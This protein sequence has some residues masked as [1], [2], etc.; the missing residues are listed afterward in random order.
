MSFDLGL[1]AKH[2]TV[3]PFPMTAFFIAM[4][5]KAYQGLSAEQKAL[6]DKSTGLAMSK[7][8]G[9]LYTKASR[10][11]LEQQGQGGAQIRGLQ[12]R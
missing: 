12:K 6:F 7:R 5:K 4:N 3:G 10:F 9:K 11:S 1:V 8:G 2:Y